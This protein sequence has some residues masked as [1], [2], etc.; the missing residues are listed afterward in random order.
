MT[1]PDTVVGTIVHDHFLPVQLKV[2]DR[3]E[4]EDRYQAHW[5]PTIL[6]LDEQGREHHRSVGYLGPEEFAPMLLL[7]LGKYRCNRHEWDECED[8]LQRLLNEYPDSFY[9]P[10]GWYWRGVLAYKGRGEHDGLSRYWRQTEQRFPNTEW[11]QKA[12]IVFV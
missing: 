4:V 1:Y 8:A 9:A 10:E 6:I 5:T 11:A 2:G 7:G 12:S 3:L